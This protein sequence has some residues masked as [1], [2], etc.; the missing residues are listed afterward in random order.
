MNISQEE[1]RRV[2]ME[3]GISYKD[4]FQKAKSILLNLVSSD[5]RVL[6]EPYP[7]FVAL[8]ELG[9]NAV[10]LVVRVWCLNSEYWNIYFEMQEKVKLTFDNEGISIPYP[11]RDIHVYNEK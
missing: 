6:N 1:K 4:D 9:D 5:N 11:Q 3:F 10:I 7:P 8:K 2:D